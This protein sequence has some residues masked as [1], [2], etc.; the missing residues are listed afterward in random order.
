[1]EKLPERGVRAGRPS[2]RPFARKRHADGVGRL[3]AV[4]SNPVRV[5]EGV[6]FLSAQNITI[7]FLQNSYVIIKAPGLNREAGE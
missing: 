2:E 3:R 1:M 6:D 4:L 5:F 7:L